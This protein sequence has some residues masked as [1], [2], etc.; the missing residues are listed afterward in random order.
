MKLLLLKVFLQRRA[1]DE[2]FTLPMVIA[3]GLVMIL[4]GVTNIVKSSEENLN[5]ITQNSSSDALA[6]AEVGITKYRELLNQNRILTIYNHD[7]WTSNATVTAQTCSIMTETPPGWFDDDDPNTNV[8]PNNTNQW[9]KIKEDINGNGNTTDDEDLVGEYKLVSYIYDNDGNPAAEDNGEFAPNDDNANTTDSFT[10]NDSASYNPRGI[11]TVQGQSNDGSEA[12]IQVEIPI[13][14]NQDDLENLAPA[15]WIGSTDSSYL[16]S[17]NSNLGGDSNGTKLTVPNTS[18]VVI[19]DGATAAVPA[20][21]G[22]PA[23]PATPGCADPT[24]GT[25]YE[26][27]SDAREIPLIANIAAKIT[28]A[29]NAGSINTSLDTTNSPIVIGQTTENPFVTPPSGETFAKNNH[30]KVIT[31]CRYYYK[32]SSINTTDNIE[33]DGIAKTT[34]YIDGTLTINHNIELNSIVS[35]D[36][37]EIYVDNANDITINS[38]SAGNTIE[39]DAFIHAPGSK[40]TVLGSGTVNINGS[41]WVDKFINTAGATVNIAPDTTKTSSTTSIPSYKAYT[42]TNNRTPRPLTSSPTNWV[43]EEVE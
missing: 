29:E 27:I 23:V 42:T 9:W 13:R 32:L 34:L 33:V 36:Y 28:E 12:Q 5:A 35:S 40:L 2:G 4:L 6:V 7:Q 38:G 41:V 18:N 21:A 22:S 30:C 16:S 1:R 14:I 20:S 43:R 37:L 26:V 17:L 25:N 11:L 10:F 3:L 8:P 39:I 15:L 31:K 19:T 24:D